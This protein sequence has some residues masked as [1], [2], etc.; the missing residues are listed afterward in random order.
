MNAC[1]GAD[2]YYHRLAVDHTCKPVVVRNFWFFCVPYLR[3]SPSLSLSLSLPP[4]PPSP[5][6]LSLSLSLS[7]PPPPLSL[8]LM[9][10]SPWLR[11][12][13]VTQL[14]RYTIL[15]VCVCVWVLLIA[16]TFLVCT[17]TW[18]QHT[19]ARKD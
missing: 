7:F 16:G 6:F 17:L 9:P 15:C 19:E 14:S 10:M 2:S 1:G 3:F 13:L 5:S 4:L 18:L 8:Q 12:S 11:I